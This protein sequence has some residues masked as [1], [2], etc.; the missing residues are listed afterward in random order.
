M[1][2]NKYEFLSCDSLQFWSK[3]NNRCTHTMFTVNESVKYLAKRDSKVY[4]ATKPFD[5]VAKR[6]S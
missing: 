6:L 2:H 3:K 1:L 4:C 5:S